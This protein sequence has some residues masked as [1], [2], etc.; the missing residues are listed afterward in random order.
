MAYWPNSAHLLKTGQTTQYSSELDDGYYQ[1]GI[2]KSYTVLSA[3]A[4]GGT[5][6]VDLTHYSGTDISFTAATKTITAAGKMGVFKAAGGETIVISG[7]G[8]AGNNGVFTT[9]S[10]DANT[11][12]VVEALTEEAAGATVVMKK[13]E[14]K[15]NNCVLDNNTGLMWARYV[16]GAM[17]T[18]GD[19]L[20][21]WT[22]VDYDI[23]AYCA[24]VNA[25]S[26][27]GYSDWRV[28]NLNELLSIIQHL[29]AAPTLVPDPTAFPSWP[30]GITFTSTTQWDAGAKAWSINPGAL[31]V[32]GT[33]RATACYCA[34]CR[35]G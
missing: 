12:V 10:A 9:V 2:A 29:T 33:A 32:L 25:A 19:G 22:G 30:T 14:A 18:A 15:S 21:P 6:N 1:K 5:T 7:A 28:A 11:V 34:L 16:S 13:R 35:G 4:F 24:A 27:G 3:G 8:E 17:G 20:M 26:V 31:S 23:F